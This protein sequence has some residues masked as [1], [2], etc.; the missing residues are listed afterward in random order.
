MQNITMA[1]NFLIA[2]ACLC[3][4]LI[5]CSSSDTSVE[6]Y[7][8]S[9]FRGLNLDTMIISEEE[10]YITVK[11]GLLL[12]DSIRYYVYNN[13]ID[14]YNSYCDG[15]FCFERVCF[16][17]NGK[18]KSYY[19]ISNI[20]DCYLLRLYDKRGKLKSSDGFFCWEAN[21]NEMEVEDESKYILVSDSTFFTFI[22]SN[23]PDMKIRTF[24]DTKSG[25]RYE[26]A[27]DIDE[28]LNFCSVYRFKNLDGNIPEQI[29]D[30]KFGLEVV[31]YGQ[32][33]IIEFLMNP[34]S[35]KLR[36]DGN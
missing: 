15:K 7:S 11:E 24:I 6:R 16:H 2:I 29:Y 13:N 19:F 34:I 35:Y 36:L 9:R 22:Y 4:L 3:A 17:E 33:T 32:D 21:V 30:L 14:C 1:T 31:D 26:D 27:F 18:I 10:M 20:N 28:F 8:L 25:R 5:S 23:P 12:H